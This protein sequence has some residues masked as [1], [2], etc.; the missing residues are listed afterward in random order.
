MASLEIM[1]KSG[2]ITETQ[3]NKATEEN[4]QKPRRAHNHTQISARARMC[5]IKIDHK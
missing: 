4:E 1:Q 5:C 2:Q 3:R